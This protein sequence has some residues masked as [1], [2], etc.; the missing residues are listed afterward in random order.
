M[1]DKST[2]K[3][4]WLRRELCIYK[5][6]FIT[7]DPFPDGDSKRLLMTY[8]FNPTTKEFEEILNLFLY[9]AWIENMYID[10]NDNIYIHT[11]I[12]GK[13]NKYYQIKNKS[14]IE[15]SAFIE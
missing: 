13:N 10:T 8:L 2:A 14:L 7:Y 5:N 3:Y 9:S 11:S 1:I 15:L 4:L 6:G 12:A